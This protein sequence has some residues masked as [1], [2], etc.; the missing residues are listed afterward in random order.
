MG[1]RYIGTISR[2][3][4]T[5]GGIIL[6][7]CPDSSLSIKPGSSI[8][9]G[10]SAQFGKDYILESCQKYKNTLL[11]QLRGIGT[12]DIAGLV[13]NGIFMDEAA[14]LRSDDQYYVSDIINCTVLDQQGN[15]L[16]QITDVWIMPANDIWV[17]HTQQGDV[18]L[19][20]IDDIIIRVDIA[21]KTI[22]IN[23]ME[24]LMELALPIRPGEENE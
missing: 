6:S 24:G 23:P 7:E 16:G 21:A 20:V 3:Y 22:I 19:P 11:V 18:P 4:G 14:L 13:E 2:A 17:L 12:Q 15:T 1:Y 10:F 5:K 9:V 8:K